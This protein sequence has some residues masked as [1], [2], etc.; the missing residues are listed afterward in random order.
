[1]AYLSYEQ[2]DLI[3][4]S[5]IPL[6]AFVSLWV[7]IKLEPSKRT[8]ALVQIISSTLF[9]YAVMLVDN[10]LQIWPTFSLDYST[11]SALSLVFVSFIAIY[12]PDL[13]KSAI[14]S[15]IIYA[16]IM[17]YQQ[18][19]SLADIVTTALT[20]TPVLMLIYEYKTALQ[21]KQD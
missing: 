5:Y 1:M 8:S 4:D 21:N 15:F 10:W 6:L 9:I 17:L 7:L 20:V 13:K 14:V 11:H 12:K 16:L 2:I 19:H 18:Y 3:A